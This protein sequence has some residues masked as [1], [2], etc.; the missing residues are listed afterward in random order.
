M[1]KFEK[2]FVIFALTYILVYSFFFF[3]SMSNPDNFPKIIPF[4]IFGMI[5]SLGF[6]A[7]VVRDIFKRNFKNVNSKKAFGQ[8][9]VKV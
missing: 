8:Q 2:I 4:H 5:L 3:N 1:G 9:P 7:V 6:I